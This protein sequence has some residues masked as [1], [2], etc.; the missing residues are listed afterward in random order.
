M[1]LLTTEEIE[2]A[3]SRN[4]D[5]MYV[6]AISIVVLLVEVRSIIR[7]RRRVVDLGP[8]VVSLSTAAP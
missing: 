8:C 5:L 6:A 4:R 2:A 1:P 7:S 3:Q